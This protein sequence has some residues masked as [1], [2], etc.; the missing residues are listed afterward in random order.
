M[1][2]PCFERADR[3]LG[4]FRGVFLAERDR[5]VAQLHKMAAVIAADAHEPDLEMERLF[6]EGDH[7]GLLEHLNKLLK[8][9]TEDQ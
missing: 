8:R 7:T 6:R 3:G 4:I 1:A 2:H 9:H 5:Q